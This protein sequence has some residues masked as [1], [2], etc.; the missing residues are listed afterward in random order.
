ML[1]AGSGAAGAVRVFRVLHQVP[2]QSAVIGTLHGFDDG[3]DTITVS[4]PM[5]EETLALSNS[6]AVHQGARTLP[7]ADL[8]RH[9]DER[10][11]VWYREVA[12]HRVATEVRL[13]AQPSDPTRAGNG[14]P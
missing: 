9:P 7:I 2:I 13:V 6:V 1:I 14:R 10:V 12:G 5:G 11:K 3:T 8:A 4:T